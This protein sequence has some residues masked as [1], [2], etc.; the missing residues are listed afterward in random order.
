MII[1]VVGMIAGTFVLIRGSSTIMRYFG[2]DVGVKDGFAETV[3]AYVVARTI[4]GGARGLGRGARGLGR[5]FSGGHTPPSQAGEG[6]RASG[7]DSEPR[8]AADNV[9]T[10]APQPSHQSAG[11][12]VETAAQSVPMSS[13]APLS[14]QGRDQA[15]PG[16]THGEISQSELGT[17]Q[18]EGKTVEAFSAGQ[19][20]QGSDFETPQRNTR[21]TA[22]RGVSPA[23]SE[24][25]LK[26]D[27]SANKSMESP[28][29]DRGNLPVSEAPLNNRGGSANLDQSYSPL[30]T[31][32]GSDNS[33]LPPLNRQ[34]DSGTINEATISSEPYEYAPALDRSEFHQGTDVLSGVERGGDPV[35]SPAPMN[36]HVG[37]EVTAPVTSIGD[38]RAPT[39]SRMTRQ[40]ET[41]T[42]QPATSRPAAMPRRTSKQVM[43]EQLN[44]RGPERSEKETRLWGQKNAGR[45]EPHDGDYGTLI[46]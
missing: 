13:E 21:R 15:V 10:S 7:P 20:Q 11:R 39:E 19:P 37:R 2:V 38:S 22:T 6:N 30:S 40:Q 18:R 24:N 41:R 3:G 29:S 5:R 45:D 25:S 12:S 44:A 31:Y 1:Y 42:G 4:I 28:R 32:T 27:I 43:R 34:S 8:G 36:R 17:M 46:K 14:T 16:T 9:D 33:P 35:S 26:R 23:R